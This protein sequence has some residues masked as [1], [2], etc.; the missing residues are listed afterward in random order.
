MYIAV[1]PRHGATLMH[2]I[3]LLLDLNLVLEC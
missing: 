2:F 1:F 3:N